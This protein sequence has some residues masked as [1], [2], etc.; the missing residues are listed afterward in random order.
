MP[1]TDQIT[2]TLRTDQ[3]KQLETMA[4][5]DDPRYRSKSEAARHILDRADEVDDLENELDRIKSANK[6]IVDQYANTEMRVREDEEDEEEEESSF[7]SRI[8]WL[9]RGK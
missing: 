2:L 6:V 4:E 5:D 9:L 3:I 7:I 1:E 8:S